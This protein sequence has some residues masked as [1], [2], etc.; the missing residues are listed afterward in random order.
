MWWARAYHP[1][2][3]HPG[4]SAPNGDH[5][6]GSSIRRRCSG[7][8]PWLNLLKLR[9]VWGLVLAKF[10]TDGAWYF[11]LF[12]LPKYLYDARGFDVKQVGYYAWIRTPPRV[13]AA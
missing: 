9:E 6:R 1:P 13:S 8:D 12:W 7:R 3:S 5:R 2:D 4:L 10:L 11:Y